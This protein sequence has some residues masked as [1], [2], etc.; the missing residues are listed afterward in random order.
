MHTMY[1]SFIP[2]CIVKVFFSFMHNFFLMIIIRITTVV[3]ALICYIVLPD[4][5]LS[6][7]LLVFAS[8]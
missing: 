5:I 3:L 6:F 7:S 2:Y 8:Q 1:S 4:G